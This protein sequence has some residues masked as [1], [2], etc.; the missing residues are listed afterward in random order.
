M[1][2]IPFSYNW[3]N[4]LD[5]QAFTTIR[6]YQPQKHCAGVR[7]EPVLKGTSYGPATIMDVKPFMLDKLNSFI[8]YLDTGYSVEECRGIILRMY[9]KID[10]TQK[11]LALI[12][13][14]KDK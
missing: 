3:N 9:P 10:F 6:I 7:V 11:Q 2:Q 4:K 13:M 14:V 1:I 8:A 5:C 12:L